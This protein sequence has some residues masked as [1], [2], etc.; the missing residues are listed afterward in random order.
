M[1]LE[2]PSGTLLRESELEEVCGYQEIGTQLLP[3]VHAVWSANVACTQPKLPTT[4]VRSKPEN[5]FSGE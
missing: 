1:P 2:N 3:Q 4:E 5:R